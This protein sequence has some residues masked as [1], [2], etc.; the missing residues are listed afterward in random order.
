M[1]EIS[2]ELSSIGANLERDM[3]KL[4]RQCAWLRGLEHTAGGRLFHSRSAPPSVYADEKRERALRSA[5]AAKT[6]AA[7]PQASPP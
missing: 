6:G 5:R 1:A 3:G 2:E 4:K 7:P